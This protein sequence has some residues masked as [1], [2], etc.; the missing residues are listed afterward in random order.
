MELI[1]INEEFHFLLASKLINRRFL[2]ILH[3]TYVKCFQQKILSSKMRVRKNI[4]DLESPRK[5]LE[6][7]SSSVYPR[8][9]NSGPSEAFLKLKFQGSITLP[10]EREKGYTCKV[11][12]KARWLM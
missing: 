11:G 5:S 4:F 6:T 2:K 3:A 10:L 8:M 9:P 7:T 12:K 1:S